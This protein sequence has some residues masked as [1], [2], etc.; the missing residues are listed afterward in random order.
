M[1]PLPSLA[2]L[3][4][5]LRLDRK[6]GQLFWRVA[7][8]RWPAGMEALNTPLPAG[9]KKGMI[10][11]Q[12]V[13]AHRVIWKMVHGVDPTGDIDHRNGKKGDNRP[14]NLRDCA[15]V[16]NQ[17]NMKL[18]ARNVHGTHGLVRRKE[19]WGATIGSGKDRRWLGTF[20]TKRQAIAA[21]R[22]AEREL[23]YHR[24]HGRKN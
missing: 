13:Y 4:E 14:R 15:H 9:Y 7:R 5:L 11:G 19:R 8:G 20:S 1:N 10:D 2:R 16:D 6:T 23:K 3:Q 21:R 22:A 24:N 17:R 12:S 18:S